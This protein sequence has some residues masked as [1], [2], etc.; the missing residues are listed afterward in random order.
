MTMDKEVEEFV[1]YLIEDIN[2]KQLAVLY[3]QALH[4]TAS[5]INDMAEGEGE[6]LD[7]SERVDYHDLHNS[8]I[9]FMASVI[10]DNKAQDQEARH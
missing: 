2:Q 4:S 3:Y 1:D 9:D 10:E 8:N 6:T 5:M 7:E